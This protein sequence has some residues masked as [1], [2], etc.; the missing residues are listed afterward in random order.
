MALRPQPSKASCHKSSRLLPGFCFLLCL[1]LII[2]VAL[3]S[4]LFGFPSVMDEE[5]QDMTAQAQTAY[6]NYAQTQ[7]SIQNHVDAVLQQASEGFDDVVAT[8]DLQGFDAYWM[9]S[10]SSVLHMQEL[11]A[12]NESE[13]RNITQHT[14]RQM[15]SVETYYKEEEYLYTYP[16]G[17]TE[18]RTRGGSAA[19]CISLRAASPDE[20][21]SS[22][23]FTEEQRQ[24]AAYIHDNIADNQTQETRP[25]SI[26]E[27]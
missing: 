25:Q 27:M 8:K 11:D 4:C 3:P 24:W 20:V 13:I 1:P 12:I 10:I 15:S 7:Q 9:A 22:I 17:T 14:V 18:I 16:D 19:G 26:W 21:M 23:G 2:F 6:G 5:I